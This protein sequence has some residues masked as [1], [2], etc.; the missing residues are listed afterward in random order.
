MRPIAKTEELERALLEVVGYAVTSARMLLGETPTYGPLRL[1]EVA[2]RT[3][4]AMESAGINPAANTELKVQI[5][6]SISAL[7][8]GEE[9]FRGSA[10]RLIETL[11]RLA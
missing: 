8:E 7:F 5:E 4:D 10:D 6:A 1:L 2:M 11:L 3:V 9:S